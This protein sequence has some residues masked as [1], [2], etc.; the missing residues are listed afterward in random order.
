M[1]EKLDQLN[2]LK[3]SLLPEGWVW[4]TMREIGTIAS[5]GTP[6]T[7]EP[8][9]FDG[10]ILWI[11][12]ADL[13]GY[14]GKLIS[15]GRRNLT[16]RGLNSSSAVLL[17]AG[18]IL[19]SSRAP[20]GYVAIASKSLATNQGF[21]NL[22]LHDGVFNEYVYYYLK[23]SKQLA[24]S[25]ASGTTFL[26]VSASRFAR[27]PIPL[28]PTTEQ[29]RIVTRIEELFTKLDAG[30]KS[31]ETVKAQLK[32]YRQS[33]LKSAFEGRLTE[34]WR[35]IHRD[36]LEPASKLL[37]RIKQEQRKKCEEELRAKGKDPTKYKYEEPEQLDVTQLPLLPKGWI[38]TNFNALVIDARYGTSQKCTAKAI[39]VP[40]LRIPNIVNGILNTKDLKY[41][42]FTK[43]EIQ[44]LRVQSGDLLVI[45][46]NGSLGIVGRSAI[47]SNI[48]G[49]FLFAS[50]L[51]RL[52]PAISEFLPA[53]LNLI[54]ASPLGRKTIEQK[55]RS[56]AGQYNVNL[57]MLRSITVPLPPFEEM[58]R[59]IP[60][61]EEQFD[62]VEQAEQAVE[63]ASSRAEI[64]EQSI[65]AK[66]FRGELVPQDPNDEPARVLLERIKSLKT[67]VK[68]D[69]ETKKGRKR[70]DLEQRRLS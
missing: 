52:R 50:Y 31:L 1:N 11:T 13:S 41:S 44:R 35:R 49:V 7:K 3:P 21:K 27:I 53:Y 42:K 59:I 67:Q 51:I 32:R 57:Q 55:T 43:D 61:I 10:E 25:F 5:G 2:G 9:N 58:K 60:K 23:A 39:G 66:A 14:A 47:V 20:V 40:V 6:S 34:E 26:E 69:Q 38:W 37:A 28:C 56:T 4:T 17:P 68:H 36:E 8:M 16:E 24:E 12:P 54:L 15:R 22:I 18:T 70:N 63:I 30:V 29:R 33:V 62:Y 65:S 48:E 64:L 46:T 45:R 19:F